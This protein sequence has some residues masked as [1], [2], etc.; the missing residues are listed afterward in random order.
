MGG[1]GA[2]PALALTAVA[3]RNPNPLAPQNQG[4]RGWGPR[5]AR[6]E[7]RRREAPRTKRKTTTTNGDKVLDSSEAARPAGLRSIRGEAF[8]LEAGASG[9]GAPRAAAAGAKR[10]GQKEKPPPR[11]ETR[12]SIRAKQR[13]LEEGGRAAQRAPAG[14]RGIRGGRNRKSSAVTTWGV[15]GTLSTPVPAP[16]RRSGRGRGRYWTR[17]WQVRSS[18]N[19]P[20]TMVPAQSGVSR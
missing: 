18:P 14:L 11:T 6:S 19:S 16:G 17:T 9:V 5:A 12:C 7:S 1:T 15:Y 8:A 13:A 10:R 4:K 2:L 20:R 3:P